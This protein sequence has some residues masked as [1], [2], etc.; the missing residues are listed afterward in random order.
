[1]LVGAK[2]GDT[3]STYSFVVR[4]DFHGLEGGVQKQPDGCGFAEVFPDIFQHIEDRVALETE[5]IEVEKRLH[6]G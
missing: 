2:G 3:T 4:Y 1:M 6:D 5:V